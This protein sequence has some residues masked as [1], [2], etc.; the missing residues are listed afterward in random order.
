MKDEFEPDGRSIP[1]PVMDYLRKI[2]VR[3][4]EEKGYSP[5]AV[6]DML[7]LSRSCIYAWLRRYRADGL[8]GLE[9]RAAPGAAPLIT[10]EMDQWLRETVLQSTPEE[11][12]YDTV[13]WTREILAEL[14]KAEFGVE[15]SGRTVSL[16]LKKVGL[17]Y[18]KP[19]YRA[20][21]QDPKEVEKFLSVTFPAIKRQAEKLRADIAFE[22]EGGVNLQTHAGRT[23]GERGHTP[24]VKRTD[25][26]GGFNVLATVQAQGHMRYHL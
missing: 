5:E 22:D 19:R 6:I 20:T 8:E 21:E 17:T 16:H 14:L 2:A 23:W 3:A 18:Q 1:G 4:V 13:L 26:R 12:G 25:A 11:H 10:A 15:V 9:T 24:D 7:G